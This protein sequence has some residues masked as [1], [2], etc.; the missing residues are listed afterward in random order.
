[1]ADVYALT[2]QLVESLARVNYV[3]TQTSSTIDEPVAGL[4]PV[5]LTT[6][7]QILAEIARQRRYELYMQGLRWEDTRRFGTAVTTTPTLLFLPIPQQ[8]CDVNP[9]SPC[10]RGAG[11]GN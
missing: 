4:P 9:A 8:E 1:M 2:N 5:V 7:A 11:E 3:R 6:Q 10:G